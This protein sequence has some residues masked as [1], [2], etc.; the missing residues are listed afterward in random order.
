MKVFQ[1]FFGTKLDPRKL[2]I[3]N[4]NLFASQVKKDFYLLGNNEKVTDK[5][6]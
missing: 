1:T 3:S 6:I 5:V 4:S 2:K